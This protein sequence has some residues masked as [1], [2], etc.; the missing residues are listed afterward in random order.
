MFKLKIA[1]QYSEFHKQN[2]FIARYE[3]DQ[4]SG[5]N[6][7]LTRREAVIN[8]AASILEVEDEDIQA[9][10]EVVYDAGKE[11]DTK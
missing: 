7:G 3:T 11:T 2:V 1:E 10:L 9:V 4:C 6:S 8:A 5:W